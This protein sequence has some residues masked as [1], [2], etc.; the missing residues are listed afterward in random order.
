MAFL[1]TLMMAS[2]LSENCGL[3]F[4]KLMNFV[5]VAE[6]FSFASTVWTSQVYPSAF[7]IPRIWTVAS[8]HHCYFIE[9]ET[10][11]YNFILLLQL[12]H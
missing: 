9:N 7:S 12:F 11:N 5:F 2:I 10:L 1:A 6:I 8:F 3:D 4:T